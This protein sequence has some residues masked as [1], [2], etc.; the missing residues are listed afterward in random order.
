MR[1]RTDRRSREVEPAPEAEGAVRRGFLGLARASVKTALALAE[2]ERKRSHVLLGFASAHAFA[3][4]QGLGPREANRLFS[5]GRAL[6][7]APE[8]VKPVRSG[9][10]PVESALAVGRVLREPALSLTPAERAAWIAKAFTVAPRELRRQAEKAVEDARQGAPTLA[11]TF[12]V[13]TQGRDAFQRSRLLM[14]RG[15]PRTLPEGEVLRRLSLSWLAQNDPVLQPLPARRA[16]PT[17]GSRCRYVPRAVVAQLQR[18][19]GGL[20]EICRVRRAQE[21]IHL[22]TRHAD[23]GGRELEDL[24]EACWDCHVLADAG[25]YRFS[26]L[27]A[28]GRPHW[29]NGEGRE[30]REPPPPP[31]LACA[32]EPLA[33]FG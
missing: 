29:T 19:S 11:L 5:L 3:Q 13:T 24:G 26:H 2:V 8:L 30:I 32:F 7:A 31:Y 21:M 23:G 12:Q 18:R 17:A 4:A 6:H 27:D 22:H 1:V 9:Q 15:R 16:G 33:A 10:V 28:E 14:S 25:V 20:C